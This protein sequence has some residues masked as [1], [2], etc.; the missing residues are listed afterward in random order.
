[1]EIVS[2]SK[3]TFFNSISKEFPLAM[4]NFSEWID[5]YKKDILWSNIFGEGASV[6]ADDKGI[7]LRKAPKFHELPL[8]FQRGILVKFFLKWNM[9]VISSP[10]PTK[11]GFSFQVVDYSEGTFMTDFVDD[12][13]TIGMVYGNEGLC[14]INAL[15][16]AFQMLNEKLQSIHDQHKPKEDG[17]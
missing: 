13:F 4:E 17:I 2:L 9:S 10:H 8:D 15:R 12:T 6:C 5:T 14:M 16:M 1:M 7:E 3:Q 11:P